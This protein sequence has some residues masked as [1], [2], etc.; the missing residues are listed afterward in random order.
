MSSPVAEVLAEFAAALRGSG[1]GWY[2]FGA[3]A[4]LIHGSRRL[5]ADIDITVLLGEQTNAALVA[6]LQAHGF[7]LRFADVEDFLAQTRVIPL[8]HERTD[9]PVDVVIG[10]PGL[11]ELFLAESVSVEL[12]GVT[13]PVVRP[14]HL[15]V[16][17]LLAGRAKDLD[18]AVAVA[19]A[20]ELDE[21][22]IEELVDAIA[23]GLG[24][25]DV[26]VRLAELRKR[27]NRR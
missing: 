10:G 5:T 20:S 14:E 2:L 13:V 17:K 12:E 16:M 18:D 22:S 27:A 11:E 25:D 9:M 6:R 19:R 4:A 7:E 21:R 24:E 26:R 3:Q 1:S 15:V 23:D 8:R